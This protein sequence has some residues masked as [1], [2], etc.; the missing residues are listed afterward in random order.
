M[1]CKKC[2]Y[3]VTVVNKPNGMSG[4][5][6]NCGGHK[7]GN[8]VCPGRT[9]VMT[10]EQI[11]AKVQVRLLEYLESYRDVE[12]QVQQRQTTEMNHLEAEITRCEDEIARLTKNL[13][14]IS[15]VDV[16]HIISAQIHEINQTLAGLKAQ[17]DTMLY[18][19]SPSDLEPYFDAILVEWKDCT[20]EEKKKVA[21]TG[22]KV[23]MKDEEATC[24][25]LSPQKND[26]L[27][28]AVI[29]YELSVEAER[30]MRDARDEDMVSFEQVLLE[31]GITQEEIDLADDVQID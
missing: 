21:Q 6:I 18:D 11:E 9:Q 22:I 29:D 30:R 7:R 12:M 19:S 20:I 3:A 4:H 26:E 25:L 27:Y 15:E 17:R 2:G 28:D 10:L 31:N 14:H 24:V 16:I 5:Y 8:S 13:T 1:K 23:V